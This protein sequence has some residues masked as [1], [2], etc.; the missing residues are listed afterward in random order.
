MARQQPPQAPPPVMKLLVRYG[1]LDRMRFASARDFARAFERGLR[2]ADVPMAYSSGFSPHPRISYVNPAP[3]G[4]KSQAEYVVIGL[5]QTRDP[6]EIR[7]RLNEA[8]PG[9]FPILEVT[10]TPPQPAFEAS[11]WEIHLPEA[12]PEQLQEAVARFEAQTEVTVERETKNGLRVFDARG[13]VQA[14]AA[15]EDRLVV[16]IRHTEPLVRPTDVVNALLTLGLE[17]GPS[18]ITRL[19]QGPVSALTH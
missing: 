1:R 7:K 11:Q 12:N 9:G 15:N 17:P 2:R 19:S 18:A 3:T 10:P 4:V 14:C 5:S 8:M 13:P 16:V 6:A